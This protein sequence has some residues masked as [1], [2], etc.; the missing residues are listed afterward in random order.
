MCLIIIGC[1]D[2]EEVVVKDDVVEAIIQEK[3]AEKDHQ[4]DHAFY[5]LQKSMKDLEYE[6]NNLKAR[7]EEYESTL[8][9]PTLNA[10]LLKLIKF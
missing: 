9:A 10:E 3:H 8:H 5:P 7:V 1:G 2:K 6:I 4:H